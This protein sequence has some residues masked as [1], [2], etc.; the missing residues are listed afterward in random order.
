MEDGGSAFPGWLRDPGLRYG[1]PSGFTRL[2]LLIGVNHGGR[3]GVCEWNP[4]GIHLCPRVPSL[5]PTS[6]LPDWRTG[7]PA[8]WRTGQLA[9]RP[10]G[11]LANWR[12][13]QLANRRTGQLANRRTSGQADWGTGRLR[14]VP[15][16]GCGSAAPS[17]STSIS[18]VIRCWGPTDPKGRRIR[19]TEYRT[20]VNTSP[21][22]R[23][24]AVSRPWRL[25]R[26]HPISPVA[27]HARK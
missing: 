2:W 5:V 21:R 17:H 7:E 16:F 22:C 23:Q 20:R 15:A 14:T 25:L 18:R 10:T 11:E 12:T 24:G 27:R 19:L 3:Q 1:I 6:R 26:Y 8:N 4:F 9:N 13:G